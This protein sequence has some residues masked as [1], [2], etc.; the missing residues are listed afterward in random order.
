MS[1]TATTNFWSW[2]G[3][4]EALHERGDT[5]VHDG[6]RLRVVLEVFYGV[7][8]TAVYLFAV[9]EKV[10]G[11]FL[12]AFEVFLE[13]VFPRARVRARRACLQFLE[14]EFRFLLFAFDAFIV[15]R[16]VELRQP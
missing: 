3:R 14:I 16:F 12:E 11:E 1:M 5:L 6:R 15:L 8:Q 9:V 13:D 4:R 2:S 10:R 7:R